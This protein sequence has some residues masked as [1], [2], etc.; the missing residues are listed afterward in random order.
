MGVQRLYGTRQIFL[1]SLNIFFFGVLNSSGD[2]FSITPSAAYL[3]TRYSD[4]YTKHAILTSVTVR[5]GG[6]NR[7][8]ITATVYYTKKEYG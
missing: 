5:G 4:I 1:D 8:T 7:K 3:K 6:C 2:G